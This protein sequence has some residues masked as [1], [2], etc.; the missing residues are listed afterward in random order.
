MRTFITITQVD[1]LLGSG[2]TDDSKKSRS[3]LA[4]NAW[5]NGLNLHIKGD[6]IPEDVVQAGA[7]AAQ[8]AANGGLFQQ[9]T[10]SGVLTSRS[11]EVDGAKVSKSYAELSTNSTALLDSDLQLALALLKPYE[12]STLQRRVN[13]G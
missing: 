5:M 6:A 9:K 12:A 3:V 10:D 13:R 7:F 2:W 1:T 4:A 11:V 8:A